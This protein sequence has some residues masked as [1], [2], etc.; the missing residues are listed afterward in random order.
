MRRAFFIAFLLLGFIQQAFCQ[1]DSFLLPEDFF[2]HK[3]ETLN[4]HLL[5]GSSISKAQEQKLDA[6]NNTKIQILEGSKTIDITS[7]VKP[8]SNPILSYPLENNGLLLIDAS[9]HSTDEISKREFTDY[10]TDNGLDKMA[11]D[12]KQAQRI[13]KIRSVSYMKTL[14][15]V[16]KNSGN[17]NEKLLKD[18]FEIV[19]EQNPYKLSYGDDVAAKVYFKG[20]PLK[21]G[22]VM[23]TIRTATGNEFPQTLSTNADGEIFFKVTREGVYLLKAINLVA[24][25][26]QE[27]ADYDVLQT[28]FTFAF[29]SNNTMPNSYKEF[30]FGNRH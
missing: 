19:L 4:L 25:K 10:L 29:S 9:Q 21:A 16:D 1:S 30:G 8:N 17:V 13:F 2:P 5:N 14:V 23:L 24:S 11:D 28:T 6:K 20:A 7:A 27:A 22:P 12:L 18:D 15:A 26:D 3:G